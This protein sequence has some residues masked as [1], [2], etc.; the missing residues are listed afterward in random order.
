MA[1]QD[2]KRHTFKVEVAQSPEEQARGLMFRERMGTNEGMLFLRNPPGPASFWMKNTLIPLDIIFIGA[3]R[4][5]INIAADAVPH[6]LD[7][8][9]SAGL[10]AAVLELNGGRAAE[11]GIVPG[12]KV[13]W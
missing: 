11:L 6:S 13:E 9:E 1:A 2:G 3:D 12:S 4:R 5:V 7:P 10:T 8:R